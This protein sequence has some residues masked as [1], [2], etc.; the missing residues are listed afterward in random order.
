MTEAVARTRRPRDPEATRTVI[1]EAACKLLAK[2]GPAGISLSEVALLAGVNRGT[3]YQHFET[4]ER[5]IEE[6]V[7]YVS[8]KLYR[9]VLGDPATAAQRVVEE[10]DMLA[11]TRNLAR[12]AMDNPELCRV[13]MLQILA[14][15][16]PSKDIFWREYSGSIARFA[17]TALAQPG[18]DVEVFSI[19]SL[20][21]HILWP[22]WARAHSDDETTCA[23]QADRFAREMLRLSL[24]GTVRPDRAPPAVVGAVPG[25]DRSDT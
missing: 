10:V 1:L 17:Q 20:A 2:D 4:R 15:E 24:H 9:A 23:A 12:F 22:V 3:A 5:L 11:V 18:I 21:G 16:D 25:G 8:D 7:S 19:I 14:A 6:T 13:W